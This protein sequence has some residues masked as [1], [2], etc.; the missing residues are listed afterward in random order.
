VRER[1]HHV[2]RRDQVLAVEVHRA[3]ATSCLNTKNT[4]KAS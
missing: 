2:L 3:L 4:S 1:H